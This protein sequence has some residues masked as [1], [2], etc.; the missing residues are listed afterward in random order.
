[1]FSEINFYDPGLAICY[2]F[3]TF[4]HFV[5]YGYYLCIGFFESAPAQI[6]SVTINRILALVSKYR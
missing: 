5:A 6:F 1:M 3:L 2:C 4:F